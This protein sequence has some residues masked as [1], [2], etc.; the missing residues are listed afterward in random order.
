M[1]EV[2][3]DEVCNTYIDKLA[4]ICINSNRK[5]LVARSV[6]K[7]V[8]FTPGGK[9]EKGETDEEALR[10]ECMEELSVNLSTLTNTAAS[11]EPYGNFE[12]HA[13][14]K[15]P[16]TIVRMTCFRVTP[17]EAELELEHLVKASAEVEELKWIDS[18]FEREKLTVTG[19]MILE[20]LKEKNLID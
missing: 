3:S 13:Y 5:Q 11:I 19:I 18:S 2:Q 1:S 14:G 20:D 6:G 8:Y 15:P 9:R 12:A 7:S 16:G 17:R 4:L 10:R